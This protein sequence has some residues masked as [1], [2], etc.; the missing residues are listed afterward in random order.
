M[1][2][3]KA[4]FPRGDKKKKESIQLGI[5]VI[6]GICMMISDKLFH[7]LLSDGRPRHCPDTFHLMQSSETLAFGFSHTLKGLC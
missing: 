1:A 3:K 4:N 7:N 5:N 6:F 2:L